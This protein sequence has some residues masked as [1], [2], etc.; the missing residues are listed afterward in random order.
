MSYLCGTFQRNRKRLKDAEAE[1]LVLFQG[2]QAAEMPEVS[3]SSFGTPYRRL[4][5]PCIHFR[6]SEGSGGTAPVTPF[7]HIPAPVSFQRFL[8]ICS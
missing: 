7:F 3:R 2:R 4:K 1:T 6:N 8:Y 5:S